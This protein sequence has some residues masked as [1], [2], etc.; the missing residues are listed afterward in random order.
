M[1][2]K[3]CHQEKGVRSR[4]GCQEPFLLPVLGRP[5]ARRV[6]P[7]STDGSSV[8]PTPRRHRTGPAPHTDAKPPAR[9]L[10]APHSSRTPNCGAEAGTRKPTTPERLL[11]PCF[12]VTDSTTAILPP[13]SPARGVRDCAPHSGRPPG[14][15]H[16]FARETI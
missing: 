1:S 9:P 12:G 6:P 15:A 10:S 2:R 7:S 13:E 3:G 5:R 16:R 8:A 4:K 14:N 11:S